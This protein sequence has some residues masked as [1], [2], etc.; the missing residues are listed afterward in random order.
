MKGATTGPRSYGLGLGLALVAAV[1]LIPALGFAE[2]GKR[3]REPKV[4][5]ITSYKPP[6]GEYAY[7]PGKCVFHKRNEF[8]VAGYNTETTG[9]LNWRSWGN[10][11][12]RG[13]GKLFISTVGP[14][15]LRIKLTKPRRRCDKTVFTKAHFD[16]EGESFDGEP[17]K[18]DFNMPI[19]NCLR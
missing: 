12:A 2:T 5:C 6:E 8:P 9:S 10:R 18:G 4:I 17:I 19:D 15:D 13:V 1:A 14:V 11:K 16:Y 7:K 3:G